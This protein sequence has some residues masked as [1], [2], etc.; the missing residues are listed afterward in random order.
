MCPAGVDAFIAVVAE[1]LCD[2]VDNRWIIHSAWTSAYLSF[3]VSTL[4]C[5]Y[6]LLRR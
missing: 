3:E 6:L 4:E 2:V 5:H 1:P